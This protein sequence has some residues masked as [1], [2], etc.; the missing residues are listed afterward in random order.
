MWMISKVVL[1]EEN[2][3][4]RIYYMKNVFQLKYNLKKKSL[5]YMLQYVKHEVSEH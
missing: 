2:C 4:V 3:S 1:R 5:N